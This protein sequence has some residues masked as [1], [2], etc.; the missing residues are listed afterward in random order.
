MY[1]VCH[2]QV[3]IHLKGTRLSKYLGSVLPPVSLEEPPLGDLVIKIF[4]ESGMDGLVSREI[5]HH[6]FPF[7]E[8]SGS[9]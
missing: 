9:V 8:G 1:K 4:S 3:Y 5:S 2:S 6:C 7:K